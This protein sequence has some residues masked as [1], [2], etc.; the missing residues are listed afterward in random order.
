MSSP[1][2][3]ARVIGLIRPLK[4]VTLTAGESATFQCELS[5]QDIAVDWFLGGT[6]LD[7]S[8]RVSLFLCRDTC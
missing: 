1:Q 2:S 7:P 3:K 8:D 5:Y 6:K 4:D